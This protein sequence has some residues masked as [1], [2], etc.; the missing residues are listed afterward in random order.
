MTKTIEHLLSPD[1][2]VVFDVDGVLAP[3]EW[4]ENYKHCMSDEEWDN[5]LAD[6]EDIYAK[7]HPLKIFQAFIMGKGPDKCYVCSKTGTAEKESKRKFIKQYEIADDHIHFV[8]NKADKIKVLDEI[9]KQLNI[10][11]K[12]IAIVEDTVETLDNIAAARDYMTIH[13]SSFLT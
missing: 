2:I 5:R 6:G 9:Q 10:P 3:Y 4:G 13:I 11:A 1:I 12:N 7:I 8:K